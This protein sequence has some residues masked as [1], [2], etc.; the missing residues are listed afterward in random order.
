[1]LSR[2]GWSRA[3]RKRTPLP[4]AWTTVLEQQVPYYHCLP[5][6]EQAELRG[7]LQVM[8]GEMNFE[9][10]AGLD[11]VDPAMRVVIA[12]Q[13]CVLLLHRPLSDLPQLRTAIVY[14]GVY[15]ARERRRTPEGIEV[16][17]SEA[18]HG[19]SWSHGVLLFSW[20]DVAYD[21]A[22]IDDGENV[23]FHEVAHAIDEQTGDFDGV[24][25]LPDRQSAG[26]W[27]QAFGAAYQ[28]LVRDLG[29]RRKTLLDPYAAEEPAEFFAVASET[30][31]EAPLAFRSAYP[32]LYQHLRDFY[33]LD[34]ATW[35]S[36][37]S[38]G[39]A[40]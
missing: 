39:S 26:A 7:M 31:L 17:S 9:A 40:D 22:H 3:R 1:M 33:H 24:P 18:R 30:F 2:T 37:L 4:S 15:R 21:A 10:G 23:V 29:R 8:L 28:D 5:E 27:E 16:E 14:P 32:D 6:A 36:C 12:A 11:G 34:P 13:A 38:A 35:A 19:E 25:P 20:E